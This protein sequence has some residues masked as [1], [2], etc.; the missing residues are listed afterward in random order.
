MGGRRGIQPL[1]R[2]SGVSRPCLER[3]PPATAGALTVTA[4]VATAPMPIAAVANSVTNKI[5]VSNYIANGQVTMIDGATNSTT[6]IPVGRTPYGNRCEHGD[7]Q[8]LCPPTAGAT[9]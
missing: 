3:C 7:Q 9:P 8:G 5:Y 4:T 1:P 2:S 6:A